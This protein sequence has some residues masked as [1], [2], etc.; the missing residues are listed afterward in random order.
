MII[1]KISKVINS[2]KLSDVDPSDKP[3][4]MY[5]VGIRWVNAAAGR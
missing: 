2:V 1:R 5:F 4:S 3:N